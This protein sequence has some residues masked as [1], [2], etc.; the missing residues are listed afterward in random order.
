MGVCLFG[1][2]PEQQS[3]D[4]E[5]AVLVG[6][7]LLVA[8]AVTPLLESFESALPSYGRGLFDELPEGDGGDR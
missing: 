6:R 2:E 8:G 1:G 5:G 7:G 3:A 4:V